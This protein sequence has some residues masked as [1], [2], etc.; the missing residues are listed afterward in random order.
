MQL[1]MFTLGASAAEA[2]RLKPNKPQSD[3]LSEKAVAT[4]LVSC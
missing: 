4:A 3:Q 2:W 1:S